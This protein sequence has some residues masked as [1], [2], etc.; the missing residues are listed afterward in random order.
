M[1][2][3]LYI[4]FAVLGLV[5]V[6]SYGP[7][8][9][10]GG[11]GR[12]WG[13]RGHGGPWG[14]G[15]PGGPWGP[16]GHPGPWG[17]GGPHG[18]PW[19]HGP[20]GPHGHGHMWGDSDENHSGPDDSSE[21]SFEKYDPDDNWHKP[22]KGSSCGRPDKTTQSTTAPTKPT[23]APTKPPT[24]PTKSPTKEPP[25]TTYHPPFTSPTEPPTIPP[26][27][28]EK[29]RPT[30]T[31]PSEPTW[32][33]MHPDPHPHPHP[34]PSPTKKAP[35]VWPTTG[36]WPTGPTWPTRPTWEP[37]TE[38]IPETTTDAEEVFTTLSPEIESCIE[39]CPSTPEFNPVCGTN[40]ETY[41]NEGKLFCAKSCGVNVE[42]RRRSACPP[43]ID[44]GSPPTQGSTVRPS[45][46]P[47]VGRT[48]PFSE[49]Q[50]CMKSCRI[51]ST[52]QPVCGSDLITYMNIDRLRCAQNCGQDVQVLC[53]K[54]CIACGFVPKT[55]TTTTVKPT[56][57]PP[58]TIPPSTNPPPTVQ[59]PV[60]KNPCGRVIPDPDVHRCIKNCPLTQEFNP[61]CGTNGVTFK[62]P[63]YLLCAQMCG[64]DVWA[65]KFAPCTLEPTPQPPTPQ[66]PTPQPPTPKPPT[67]IE[68]P[69]VTLPPNVVT[70]IPNCPVTS[71]YDP[72]CGTDGLTYTNMGNLECSK[73]C[74]VDVRFKYKSRCSDEFDL[75]PTTPEV[76]GNKEVTQTWKT[77]PTTNTP[78]VTP[79]WSTTLGFTIP[80]DVLDDI[81]GTKKP[82]TTKNPDDE[83]EDL[84][85]DSRFGP[86]HEIISDK[87]ETDK[88]GKVESN[89][90]ETDKNKVDK[91]KLETDK[92]DQ[93]KS[94]KEKEQGR[95]SS[96]ITFPE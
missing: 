29:P 65:A 17:H 21:D 62:N 74:G 68:P 95:S 75:R 31:V 37:T 20:G 1:K 13:H 70:C 4:A 81:F 71:E 87:F 93:D 86:G 42:I 40:G 35:P 54:A 22:C 67:T 19:G 60:T 2:T 91:D 55:T 53:D 30:R 9:G 5:V 59:P 50:H 47:P 76:D 69:P 73:Y 72:V 66:P 83:D 12:G 63:G 15:G 33:T 48:T 77:E 27:T 49:F 78:P 58:P 61:V 23:T 36:T 56:T 41:P 96:N 79:K 11:P 7:G 84:D 82:H 43:P 8:G 6:E 10:G 3:F 44:N 16:G 38:V 39:S 64:I 34:H 25:I 28:S 24:E 18:H 90:D 85:L 45:P 32:P 89:K 46:T 94:D 80:P 14:P 51:T 52:F 92:P 26:V 88:S 57:Y